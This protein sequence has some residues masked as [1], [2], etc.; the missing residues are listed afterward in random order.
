M[1]GK[2]AMTDEIDTSLQIENTH[3]NHDGVR[4]ILDDFDPENDAENR[5]FGMKKESVFIADTENKITEENLHKL[6]MLSVGDFL[7]GND[8]LPNG[9]FY[10]NDWQARDR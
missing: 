6:Y 7:E 10:R 3:S 4:K 8:R 5:I 9:A 1:L 2:K